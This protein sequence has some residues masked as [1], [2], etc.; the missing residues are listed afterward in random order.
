MAEKILHLKDSDFD[1][2]NPNYEY[3]GVGNPA[4]PVDE[5]K[6]AREKVQAENK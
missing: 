4:T 1:P 2:A 3:R 6:I 5:N